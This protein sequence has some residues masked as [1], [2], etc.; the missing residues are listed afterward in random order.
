MIPFN[1]FL[2]SY[3]VSSMGCELRSSLY[4][5]VYSSLVRMPLP[6]THHLH[7]ATRLYGSPN[8]SGLWQDA[9]G[10]LR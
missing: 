4:F 7:P 1:I 8:V 3:T 2:P 5:C 9:I 6:G 10:A